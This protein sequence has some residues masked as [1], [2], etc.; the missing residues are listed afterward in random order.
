MN[1]QPEI[2]YQDQTVLVINKPAGLSVNS[3]GHKAEL[4]LADWVA[5]KFP[6]T[7][8]VGEPMTLPDG[9]VVARPG[10]VHR[11]DKDTSGVMIIALNQESFLW[12]KDQFQNRQ[13]EKTY[14]AILYGKFADTE[15]EQTID[16]P[17]GRSLKDP[18]VRV[19]SFK[20]ASNLREAV[21]VFRV[22]ET[23]GDY[24]YVEAKPKTGRT[25]QLRPILSPATPIVCD[26]LYAKGK[27]CPLGLARQALHALR[28]KIALP[29]GEVKEFEAPLSADIK[30][31]LDNLRLSC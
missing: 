20:A 16:L 24:S 28:L 29:G 1:F 11:L 25:H 12:L 7:I 10:I 6:Q 15:S 13:A 2:I 8:E 31:A 22:L 21:T 3:D 5:G 23:I 27:I 14:H 19:A 9:R 30:N 4:T 18:R 26:Y 17:I